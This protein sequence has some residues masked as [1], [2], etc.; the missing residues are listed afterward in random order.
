MTP[1]QAA[2]LIVALTALV[3]AVGA[4]VVQVRALRHDLNGHL[5][6]VIETAGQLARKEGELAGRDFGETRATLER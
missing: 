5:A 2:G 6:K 1:E 3:T 4:L